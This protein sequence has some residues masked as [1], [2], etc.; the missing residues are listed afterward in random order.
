MAVNGFKARPITGLFH[1]SFEFQLPC[2]A[3]LLW[4]VK[5]GSLVG[6]CS[7]LAGLALLDLTDNDLVTFD[8]VTFG[9]V[10]E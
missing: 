10:W 5:R 2:L 1:A 3:V 7:G 8:P 9:S 4:V 6:P